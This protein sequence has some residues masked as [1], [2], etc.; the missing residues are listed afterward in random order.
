MA[1]R[2]QFVV[3]ATPIETLVD[4]S[5]G[6]VDIIASEIG[7]ALG[8][9]GD[10]ITLANYSSALAQQ[11]YGDAGTVSYLDAIHTGEGTKLSTIEPCDAVFIKNTGHVYSSS[12]ILGAVSTDYVMVVYKTL[13]E[14]D[15]SQS[16]W[17][18]SQSPYTAA[19]HYFM[20]AWL[21]P[22]Q[23]IA[24]PGGITTSS[25]KYDLVSGRTAELSYINGD[26]TDQ[27]DSQ[28]YCKT[29]ASGGTAATDGN[30]VEFLCVT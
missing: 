10:S 18:E 29:F 24:L 27:G 15:D 9:S 14:V 8:G 26:A 28:I 12:T 25:N 23:A 20:I 6:D 19:N 30:A 5:A 17:V 16:G 22:G 11:G 2:I 7:T 21:A 13:A 4:E 1:D 3:S